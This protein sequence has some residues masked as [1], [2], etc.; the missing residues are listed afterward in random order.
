MTAA[1]TMLALQIA[2]LTDLAGWEPVGA[3]AQAVKDSAS[4]DGGLTEG[5]TMRIRTWSRRW[6][7]LHP[8]LQVFYA[9]HA[10]VDETASYVLFCLLTGTEPYGTAIGRCYALWREDHGS[11]PPFPI[12]PRIRLTG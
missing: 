1:L 5:D 6:P 3:L 7:L 2:A 4:G 11:D 9:R 12:C 8:D 10:P